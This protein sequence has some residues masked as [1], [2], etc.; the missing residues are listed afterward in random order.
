M[1]PRATRWSP[2]EKRV[3]TADAAQ[4]AGEA[5]SL[6]KRAEIARNAAHKRGKKADESFSIANSFWR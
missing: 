6:D 3:E 1:V 4:D 2:I 5:L